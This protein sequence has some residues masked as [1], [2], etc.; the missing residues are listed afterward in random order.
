MH[1]MNYRG[2]GGAV[3]SCSSETNLRVQKCRQ[4]IMVTWPLQQSQRWR[5]LHRLRTRGLDEDGRT[6][7]RASGAER[8]LTAGNYLPCLTLINEKLEIKL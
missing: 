2:T 8:A 3:K 6:T 1:R 4:E 5:E 7:R